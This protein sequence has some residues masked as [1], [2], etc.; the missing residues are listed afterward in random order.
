MT[1]YNSIDPQTERRLWFTII[2]IFVIILLISLSGEA[3]PEP[4]RSVF[5]Q[6]THYIM[7]HSKKFCKARTP[8]KY[9]QKQK[10]VVVLFHAIGVF[11]YLIVVAL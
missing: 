3:K 10:R 7:R 5:G 11:G 4:P 8:I 2:L 1:D 9:Q 6:P